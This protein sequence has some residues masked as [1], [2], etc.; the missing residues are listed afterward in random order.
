MIKTLLVLADSLDQKGF[1]KEAYTVTEIALD[2]GRMNPEIIG[3][4]DQVKFVPQ[5]EGLKFTGYEGKQAQIYD[6]KWLSETVGKEGTV[7]TYPLN[8]GDPEQDK[9]WAAIKFPNGSTAEVRVQ[10]LV[11]R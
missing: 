8:Y 11:S 7:V 9:N 1:Y 5:S 4:G 2:Y 3:V 6:N 10:D